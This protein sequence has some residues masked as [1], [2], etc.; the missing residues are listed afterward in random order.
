[1]SAYK[2]TIAIRSE[3]FASA[4]EASARYKNT[5]KQ[6]GIAPEVVRR[7][8][9]AAYEVELNQ[10][11]HS[12]GGEMTMEITPGAITLVAKDCGPGIP[13]IDRAMTEGFS[14]APD[15]VRDLGFGAGMGLPNMRRNADEFSIQSQMGVG[16]EI[17]MEFHIA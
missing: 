5:L 9:I 8:S 4:G 7:F 10:V 12:M 15:S 2:E 17:R 1:M 13:D 16:T 3:D 6:L 14:T 11:I